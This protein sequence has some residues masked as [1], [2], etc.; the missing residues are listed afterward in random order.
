MHI[1]NHRNIILHESEWLLLR[2]QKPTDVS[3]DV[4]KREHLDG[5]GG[6]VN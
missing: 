6:N 5:I 4:E 1:K 2:S 3:I